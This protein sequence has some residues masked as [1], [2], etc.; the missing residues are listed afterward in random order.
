[1]SSLL[2]LQIKWFVTKRPRMIVLVDIFHWNVQHGKRRFIPGILFYSVIFGF[3]VDYASVK[4]CDNMLN[5]V[6]PKI[7]NSVKMHQNCIC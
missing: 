4:I 2:T 7:D 5:R 1:M 6:F 3:L